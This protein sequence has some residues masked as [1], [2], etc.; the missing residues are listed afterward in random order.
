MITCM[1]GHVWAATA[2]LGCAA[3]DDLTAVKA[4]AVHQRLMVAALSCDAVQLSTSSSRPIKRS[5]RLQIAP[6]EFL[7]ALERQNRTED[8]HAFKNA[9]CQC[10][11]D[12]KHWR[13][14]GVL[15]EC[16]GSVC[17][18]ARYGKTTWRIRRSRRH[19]RTAPSRPVSSGPLPWK[20]THRTENVPVRLKPGTIILW[21]RFGI[22]LAELILF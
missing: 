16:E 17:R 11:L 5:C 19:P 18:S 21:R 12:A 2:S 4:A 14:H 3:S 13:H 20:T 8:F 1:A 9:A 15:H 22:F 6:G 10:L 7:P